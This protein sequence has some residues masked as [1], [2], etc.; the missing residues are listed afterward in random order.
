M[1]K[2]SIKQNCKIILAS[3]SLARKKIL[4]D[5]GLE[6]EVIS[7]SFDEE[8]AK[9]RIKNLSIKKQAIYLAK[10]KALS[11]SL[12]YP[13][14]ITIGSDQICE[15]DGLAIDK[16]K[17]AREAI[18]QLKLLRGKSHIQNNSTCLYRGKK[19][20]FQNY[21]KA[22]LILRDLSDDEI[23]KYVNFDRSWGCA[24][25]YKFESLGKHLFA[26]VEGSDNSI[27]GMNILPL[28]NFL[29]QKQLISL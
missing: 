16:S 8:L 5:L 2:F 13:D 22:K 24:G 21:S 11:I 6:F 23:T 10:Q 4:S 1:I 28:I 20:L 19:L 27:I 15:L 17:N 29:Y 18:A 26:K 3:S 25:S 7:P 14:S 12:K 9:P